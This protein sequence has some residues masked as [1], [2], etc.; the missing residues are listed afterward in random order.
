MMPSTTAR[1]RAME[2]REHRDALLRLGR[3]YLAVETRRQ[4]RR[5]LG[6]ARSRDPER[7]GRSEFGAMTAAGSGAA[8][9]LLTFHRA[10]GLEW[11]VVFVTGL[12]AGLVPISW[13]TGNPD[14][15]AEER[16]L[17]HVALGRSEGVLHVSWAR[18]RT[19]GGR[20]TAAG[21]E[22]VADAAPRT[23]CGLLHPSRSIPARAWPARATRSSRAT[24]PGR[25][26]EP[27]TRRRHAR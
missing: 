18:Q 21:T 6:L 7:L 8:V 11:S 25:S 16:R 17:L 13:A 26:L 9:D 23:R 27:R 22:P 12:E 10:K 1:A 14:A 20:P 5:L 15:L 24:P 19:V 2:A 3:E 4:R